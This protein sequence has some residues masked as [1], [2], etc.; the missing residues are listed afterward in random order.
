MSDEAALILIRVFV[1]AVPTGFAC[2]ILGVLWAK[3]SIWKQMNRQIKS[4]AIDE[5]DFIQEPEP[6]TI[7]QT[8]VTKRNRKV[9]L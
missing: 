3:H 4:P 9:K 6:Q 1:I 8:T 5:P 2:F 7:A